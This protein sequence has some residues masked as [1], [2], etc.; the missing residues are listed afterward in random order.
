M[1]RNRGVGELADIFVHPFLVQVEGCPSPK[2]AK[3]AVAQW[4]NILRGAYPRVFIN[5]EAFTL[6]GCYPNRPPSNIATLLVSVHTA[7]RRERGGALFGALWYRGQNT[8]YGCSDDVFTDESQLLRPVSS[9]IAEKRDR[10]K[11]SPYDIRITL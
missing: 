2:D 6:E 10:T 8:L 4:R 1:I 3:E 9:I 7:F 11:E 5:G